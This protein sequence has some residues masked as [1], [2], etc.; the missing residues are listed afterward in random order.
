MTTFLGIII[1]IFILGLL[2][3]SHE[4]GHFLMAKICG[5][6]VIEFSLGMGPRICSWG[7][8]ETRYSLKAIPFGGS[9]LM[10]GED[11]AG[12]GEID[13]DVFDKE[14][15]DIIEPENS[16]SKKSVWA[17]I[18][19]VIGGPLFNFLLAFLLGVILVAV[20]G[21]N[22]PIVYKVESGYGAES[23]GLQNGDLITEINGHSIS[24]G[25]D[26][27]L[28][29]KVYPLDG[30]ATVSFIRDGKEQ[31]VSYDSSFSVYR[32]GI[33]YLG[34][35]ESARLYSIT[36]GTPAYES[37]LRN[38]DVVTSING[39]EIKTGADMANYFR[40]NPASDM[41]ITFT[42]TR[43]GGELTTTITPKLV[44]GH[45][46]G[47]SA[48]YYR[49]DPT[50]LSAIKGGFKEMMY[51]IRAVFLSVKML[52][53]GTVSVSEVSGPVG[54]VAVISDTVKESSQDGA[55]YVLI[56]MM[57]LTILL[58]ANL[59]VVNLLP[60][61]ALDGGR[62]II[63]LVEAIFKKKLPRNIELKINMAGF[64]I[65]M[66]FMVVVLFNDVFKLF[67]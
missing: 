14:E 15:A 11:P 37:G 62:F 19:V 4:F 46:L 61:P 9:C 63:L 32:V 23:A 29:N 2:I 10:V 65:L 53:S 42:V 12:G 60:F 38:D 64:M 6:G 52:V 25:Q 7:K 5:I 67:R 24:L 28:Y 31:I 57:M 22:D 16:F 49:S 33:N 66:A 3:V 54:V 8:G 56:N 55:L 20:S 21:S 1:A 35:D 18:L 27:E 17:R 40:E 47:F 44:T 43:V 58:S 41:P 39:T 48:S 50:F 26:I 34:D 36:E 51:G 13:V 59:G 45:T 30:D